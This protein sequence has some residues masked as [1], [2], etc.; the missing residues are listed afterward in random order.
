MSRV[1]SCLHKANETLDVLILRASTVQIVFFIG[2]NNGLVQAQD[3]R[4]PNVSKHVR[5]TIYFFGKCLFSP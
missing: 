3:R 1:F 4:E 5:R 2:P